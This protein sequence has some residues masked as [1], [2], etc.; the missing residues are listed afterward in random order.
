MVIT[1]KAMKFKTKPTF[2][3]CAMVTLPLENTIALGGVPT[4][5]INAQLEAKVTGIHNCAIS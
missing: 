4:G 2:A 5:S 3:I 1:A